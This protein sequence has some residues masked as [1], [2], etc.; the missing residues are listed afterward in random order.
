MELKRVKASGVCNGKEAK[1]K[2][3]KPNEV[4]RKT[5]EI[6]TMFKLKREEH[7]EKVET[8]VWNSK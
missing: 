2:K 8:I 5:N 3:E 1:K 6:N 4:I 7:S